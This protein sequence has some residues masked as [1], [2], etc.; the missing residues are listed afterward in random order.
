MSHLVV[1]VAQNAAIDR[2]HVSPIHLFDAVGSFSVP[3]SQ[4]T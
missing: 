3:V 2:R 1:V 4:G